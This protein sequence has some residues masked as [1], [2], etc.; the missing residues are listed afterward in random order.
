M[1]LLTVCPSYQCTRAQISLSCLPAVSSTH[2]GLSIK[3]M[4]NNRAAMYYINWQRGGRSQALCTKS[5]KLCNRCISHHIHISAVYLPGL[6]NAVPD[7]ISRHFSLHNEWELNN[8]VFWEICLTWGHPQIG[9]FATPS[10]MKCRRFCS[11][12]DALIIPW[13]CVLLY[14]TIPTTPLLL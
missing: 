9:L 12:R 14:T 2:R 7:S 4:L 1:V 6:Q 5:I 10:N 13:P 3:I 11:R 8:E